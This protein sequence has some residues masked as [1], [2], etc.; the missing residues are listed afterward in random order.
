M[1]ATDNAPVV[2]LPLTACAP[3]HPP[4]ALQEVAFVADQVSVLVE[5]AATAVGEAVSVNVGAGIVTVTLAV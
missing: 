1:V 4:L 5:P 2:K 3:L